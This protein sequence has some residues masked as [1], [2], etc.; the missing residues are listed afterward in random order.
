M[1]IET[2]ADYEFNKAPLVK[3]M[4]LISQAIRPDFPVTSV[5][6]QLA[7]LVEQAEAEIPHQASIQERIDALLKLFYKQWHFSGASGKYCLSDTLWVD[8]VL[9]THIGSPV[10]LGSI[11]IY[12]AQAINLPLAPVIFP[13]QLIIR[14]DIPDEKP[15]FLNP[16][17]GEY[18]SRHTL[19]VW[20]KGNVGS[21]SELSASDLEESEHSSII[22]KLLDTLKVSLMEEKKMEQA[23]KTSETVLLFD[24]E[25]PYE[26]RDRGLIYAQLEC[27]HVA[28]SDLN[29]FVEQ[30][31]EDPISE[32]I[33]IQIHS[34]EQHPVVLH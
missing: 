27:N 8:K 28:L 12:I 22:R 29:Y 11:L 19:D 26:I 3:G 33:K 25:D 17:N 4:I 2:I 23:L 13:T 21:T 5:G 10:S 9:A 32:M 24:P 30:C 18:L 16:I 15:L 6:Y 1:M 14:I 31:P 34:I 20:L 7:Q